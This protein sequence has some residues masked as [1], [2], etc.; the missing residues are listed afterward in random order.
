MPCVWRAGS[1]RGSRRSAQWKDVGS[2]SITSDRPARFRPGPPAIPLRW[3]A[4]TTMDT[5][6]ST[7]RPATTATRECPRRR[8]S[9][10]STCWP[11]WPATAPRSSSRSARAAWPRAACPCMAS[12]SPE[13]MVAQMR[14]KP[15][16]D[17]IPVTIGDMASTRVEGA[18]KVVYND[19]AGRAGGVLRQRR[20]APPGGRHSFAIEVGV[21]DLAARP[22]AGALRGLRPQGRVRRVRRRQPRHDLPPRRVRRGAPRPPFRYVAR[23]VDPAPGRHGWRS[24]GRTGTTGPSPATAAGT[25]R[26]LARQ[27]IA[28]TPRADPVWALCSTCM[29]V[30]PLL[31]ATAALLV[32]APAANASTIL[33][34]L[35]TTAAPG[36]ASACATGCPV[37]PS[38]GFQQFALKGATVRRPEDG[39]LSVH[40]KRDRGHEDPQIA[41][42]RPGRGNGMSVAASAP[43]P[44][45]PGAG[46]RVQ[47]VRPAR[48][49]ARRLDRL[50][51]PHRRGRPRRLRTARA[52][53]PCRPSRRPATRA[54]WTAGPA[55]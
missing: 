45:S 26:S 7:S 5:S 11:S 35:D 52:T 38:L 32:S 47:V 12:S 36:T 3:A 4:C 55:W 1:W 33:G 40:A 27:R 9:P 48:R 19:H 14:A 44:V 20:R 24:A 50:P 51:V 8:S 18:F 16:G 22:D 39:V 13:A 37:A 54:A 23:R 29:T 6:T 34:S 46:E 25:S 30:R 17:A 2:C 49:Q 21:P 10:R 43:V 53:A 15:G 31:L 28:R 42:L 41:V